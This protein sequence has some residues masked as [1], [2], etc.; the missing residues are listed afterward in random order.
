[1][2]AMKAATLYRLE[3]AADANGE[4]TSAL[5][6]GTRDTGFFIPGR[7][8][9]AEYDANGLALLFVSHDIP[10][11]EQ[12][13]ILLIDPQGGVIDRATLGRSYVSGSFVP[14][15]IAGE[16]LVSFQFFGDGLWQVRL[17]QSS[18][19]AWPW[20][21]PAG[22]RRYRAYRRWFDVNPT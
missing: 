8:L 11:E 22:V 4:A 18:G 21:G 6:R 17:R 20:S 10:Y 2:P 14:G 15:A 13:E 16:D 5:W 9:E 19:F 12:L 1:M 7:V 3:P